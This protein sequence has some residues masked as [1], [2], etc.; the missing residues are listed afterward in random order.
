MAQF[1]A[2]ICG[3]FMPVDALFIE[4]ERLYLCGDDALI[5]FTIPRGRQGLS[6]QLRHYP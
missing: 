6:W 3:R 4:S 1:E 5:H 2:L